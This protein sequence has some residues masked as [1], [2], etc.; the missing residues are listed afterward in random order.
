MANIVTP[1][2][3]WNL[4]RDQPQVVGPSGGATR[5][6]KI[7]QLYTNLSASTAYSLQHGL[8]TENGTPA[9]P[10]E[11]NIDPASATAA[12]LVPQANNLSWDSNYIYINIQA[13]SGTHAV[14]LTI[15]F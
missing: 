10:V 11:A 7:R 4:L 9:T 8:L 6:R 13:A 14:Y 1:T 15:T 3:S 5:Y 2:A 12:N